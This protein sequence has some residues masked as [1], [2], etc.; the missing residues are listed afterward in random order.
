MPSYA[1]SMDVV[2]LITKDLRKQ[3]QV[4]D[5]NADDI[6]VEFFGSGVSE[7]SIADRTAIANLCAEYGAKT[8]FFPVDEHTL[9]YLAQTGREQHSIQIMKAYLQK[10]ALFRSVQDDD[11]AVEYHKVIEIF[12]PDIVVTISGPCKPKDKVEL[13]DVAKDFQ[14]KFGP[15]L[16]IL[17]LDIDGQVHT[18]QNGSVLLTSIASCSNR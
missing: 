1:T 4:K 5:E 10:S 12:L 13:E 16:G 8:G 18:V 2:L 15:S 7:L 9:D 3:L 14:S 17:N 6:F 11:N